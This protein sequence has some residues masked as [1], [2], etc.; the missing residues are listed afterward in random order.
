VKHRSSILRL[1]AFILLLIFSQKTGVDLLVHNFFHADTQTSE[2]RE[3]NYAC[4][5]I[6]DFLTPFVEEERP[7]L[8]ASPRPLSVFNAVMQQQEVILAPTYFS[9]RGPPSLL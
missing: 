2:T 6:D 9:L 3:I 5:C 8:A 7:V 4:S 1:A